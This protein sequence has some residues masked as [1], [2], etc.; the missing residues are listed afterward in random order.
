M[1]VTA[2]ESTALAKVAYDQSHKVLQLQFRSGLRYQ[3]CDVP[4]AV[5][6]ALLQAPSKGKYF[7]RSIRVCFRYA[8][9]DSA[10][11]ADLTI[12]TGSGR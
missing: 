6:E 11:Q 1:R 3:Y 2:V 12:A 4:E 7:N 10:A 5:H 8:R 9:L